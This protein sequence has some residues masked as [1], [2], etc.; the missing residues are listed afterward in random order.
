MCALTVHLSDACVHI[1]MNVGL[2]FRTL[3][4]FV[5]N[6]HFQSIDL[7]IT[8]HNYLDIYSI[9]EGSQSSNFIISIIGMSKI[10]FIVM[11]MHSD[12]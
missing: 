12:I 9:G 11:I 3:S 6:W 10:H 2:H 4:N 7:Y 1:V 8:K 5:I